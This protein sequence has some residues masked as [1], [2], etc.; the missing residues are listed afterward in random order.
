MFSRLITNTN[1]MFCL[2]HGILCPLGSSEFLV[3]RVKSLITWYLL[4]GSCTRTDTYYVLPRCLLCRYGVVW[5]DSRCAASRRTTAATPCWCKP[6]KAS[7]QGAPAF[8]KETPGCLE[9]A[10]ATSPRRHQQLATSHRHSFFLLA[11][12]SVLRPATFTIVQI[13]HSSTLHTCPCRLAAGYN[14]Q[15]LGLL[16]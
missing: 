14:E 13:V 3:F 12:V 4:G 10:N 6:A 1:A 2:L 16:G 5:K 8:K 11:S 9:A 7:K 15:W